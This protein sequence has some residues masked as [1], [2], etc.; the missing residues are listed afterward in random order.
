VFRRLAVFPGSFDFDAAQAV[1]AG[2]GIEPYQVLDLLT[3][4]IDK[5]LVQVDD[6]G[7]EARHRLLETVRQSRSSTVK[8]PPAGMAVTPPSV[9]EQTLPVA[10]P[11]TAT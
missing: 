9:G 6:D 1:A 10:G 7:D 3:P 8:P 11:G 5:S 4:V 2:N